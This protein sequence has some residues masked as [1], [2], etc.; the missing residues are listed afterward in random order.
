MDLS[1]FDLSAVDFSQ[2]RAVV[3]LAIAGLVVWSLWLYRFVLSRLSKPATNDYRTTTSVVV[4]SFHEDP[5]ILMR[6][7]ETWR[8]QSPDE[9]LVV[10]DVADTEAR[11]SGGRGRT[12]QRSLGGDERVAPHATG[13]TV[14]PST[15]SARR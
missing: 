15:S 9:I 2:W 11:R 7:L 8:A 5:D 13:P 10:L 12:R 1:S 4:P 14:D 6:C 3:P